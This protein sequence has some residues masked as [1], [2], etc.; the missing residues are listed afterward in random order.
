MARVCKARGWIAL[1]CRCSAWCVLLPVV[2]HVGS[3]QNKGEHLSA[4]VCSVFIFQHARCPHIALFHGHN[5]TC[6][7]SYR[8]R[9]VGDRDRER[10]R[11]RRESSTES[12]ES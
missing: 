5:C 11:R 12:G 8:R 3:K 4:L 6:T 9:R 7:D 1:T 2:S 10:P